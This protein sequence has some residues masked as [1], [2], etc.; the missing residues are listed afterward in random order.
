MNKPFVML[1]LVVAVMVAALLGVIAILGNINSAQVVDA[2]IK[3]GFIL[4][5]VLVA[6]LA[7]GMLS[8]SKDKK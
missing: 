6:G 5:V 2:G 4:V 8:K 7:I 3:I 1:V